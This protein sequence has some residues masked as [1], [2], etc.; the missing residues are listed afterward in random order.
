LEEEGLRNVLKRTKN[1]KLGMPLNEVRTVWAKV[2][3]DKPNASF[4]TIDLNLKVV[5]WLHTPNQT[6]IFFGHWFA[7]VS[8]HLSCVTRCHTNVNYLK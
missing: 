8:L 1:M 6:T 7:S 2:L 5:A 3:S 4:Q